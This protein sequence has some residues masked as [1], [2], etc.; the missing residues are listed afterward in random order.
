MSTEE[1]TIDILCKQMA[2]HNQD[3]ARDLQ[4]LIDLKDVLDKQRLKYYEMYEY[5]KKL[6][7]E[8]KELKKQLRQKT[9]LKVES[10][11]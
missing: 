3:H 6:A 8:N 1:L 5:A 4:T 10:K 7:E 11:K 9:G 2:E